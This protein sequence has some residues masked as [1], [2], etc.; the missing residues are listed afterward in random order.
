[1]MQKTKIQEV[2]QSQSK[3]LRQFHLGLRPPIA[4]AADLIPLALHQSVP[5]KCV[6][7]ATETLTVHSINPTMHLTDHAS[8]PMVR[9]IHSLILQYHTNSPPYTPQ[10]THYFPNTLT[11]HLLKSNRSSCRPLSLTPLIPYQSPHRPP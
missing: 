9:I 8:H 4:E 7:D 6:T 5:N 10:T 1:M 11:T 3:V 2:Q